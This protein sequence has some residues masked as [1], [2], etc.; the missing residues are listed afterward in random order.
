MKT[1]QLAVLA[2]AKTEVSMDDVLAY[3]KEMKKNLDAHEGRTI[4][5]FNLSDQMLKRIQKR[6]AK[7]KVSTLEDY[8]AVL[9]GQDLETRKNY[10]PE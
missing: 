9:I 3:L 4:L 1:N 6:M 10:F 8:V 7:K 2:G 5:S